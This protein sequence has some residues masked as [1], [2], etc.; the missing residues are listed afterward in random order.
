LTRDS[1]WIKGGTIGCSFS[2]SLRSCQDVGATLVASLFSS[3]LYTIAH[4]YTCC[5]ACTFSQK[6]CCEAQFLDE[7]Y[8]VFHFRRW[9]EAQFLDETSNCFLLPA[10]ALS[11]DRLQLNCA[12]DKPIANCS[13]SFLF[14]FSGYGKQGRL[15][16]GFCSASARFSEHFFHFSRV[17]RL[18]MIAR[19][20]LRR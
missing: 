8:T 18:L 9:P 17:G 16:S 4:M 2:L 3:M 13:F 1:T 7:I 12:L 11:L 5:S 19:V 15:F 20:V 14:L 6:R 10:L